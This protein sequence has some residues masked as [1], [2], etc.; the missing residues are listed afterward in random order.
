[1]NFSTLYRNREREIAN[2]FT[3]TFAASE[4]AE[5]GSLIGDLAL[6][7][8][9]NTAGE[10][11]FVISAW[12]DDALVASII[13]S[14]LAYDDGRAVFVLGPVAVTTDRQG[15]GIGQRIITHGLDILRDRGVDVVLT[16]GDPDYYRHV[17]FSPVSEADIPAPFPLQQPEGWQGQSLTGAALTSLRGPARCVGAFDDPAFW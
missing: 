8:M 2:L 15:E 6:R 9:E 17:G 1:M 5:E 16:Y 14:R 12:D 3:T 11:L 13:F 10:D 4:G 7:L